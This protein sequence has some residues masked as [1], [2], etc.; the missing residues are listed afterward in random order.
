MALKITMDKII[1][2]DEKTYEDR[3]T[4]ITFNK[5]DLKR[6]NL[7]CDDLDV[8]DGCELTFY[9]PIL[10]E[11]LKGKYEAPTRSFYKVKTG[12]IPHKNVDTGVYLITSVTHDITK[13]YICSLNMRRRVD[14]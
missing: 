1:I 9:D 11:Y 10:D 4:V 13:G 6:Y 12:K 3:E 8:Y 5:S 2:F 14:F 7:Q